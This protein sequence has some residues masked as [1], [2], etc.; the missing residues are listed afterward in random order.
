MPG[1]DVRGMR[2]AR[3]SVRHY[4]RP[5][6]S[7]AFVPLVREIIGHHMY[8]R[9]PGASREAVCFRAADTLDFLGAIGAARVPAGTR[10]PGARRPRKI[11]S[12][13]VP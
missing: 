13:N 7:R 11:P 4:N 3:R 1:I 5:T 8:D 6:E 9:A 2:S 10:V 12:R